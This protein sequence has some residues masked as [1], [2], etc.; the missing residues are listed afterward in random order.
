MVTLVASSGT[1][2]STNSIDYFQYINADK[3]T[4]STVLNLAPS[5]TPISATAGDVYFDSGT[6]KLRAYDG[7]I[8][9]DLW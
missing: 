7:S 8:W 1:G 2:G 6:S 3:L 9:N 5:S 4:L